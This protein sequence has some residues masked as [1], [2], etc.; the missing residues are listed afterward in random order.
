LERRLHSEP[1]AYIT[2]MR[3]FWS[4]PLRVETGVLIPRPDTEILV[5]QALQLEQSAP[6]GCI[7]DLGTGSGAIGIAVALE[8]P[9]RQI[10]A[11]ER[12]PTALPVANSNIN[13][14]AASN[15]QLIQASWLDCIRDDSVAMVLANPPYLASDDPH[16]PSLQYEPVEALVSG[17][18]GL[19]D[20]ESIISQTRRAARSCAPLLLEHGS[21]QGRS[22]RQLMLDYGYKDVCTK[23]DLAGHERV[24]IGFV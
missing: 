12:S 1:L 16:L 19:E 4:T 22:V 23:T 20:L 5:E 7:L 13:D 9:L 10:V 8:L 3:E 24:S 2:G 15:V 18:S 17:N 14:L 11:I 21:D 6:A